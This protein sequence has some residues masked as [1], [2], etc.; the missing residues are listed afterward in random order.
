MIELIQFPWS[1]FC[2][3]ARAILQASEAKFK[4][5]NIPN[6]D[7]TLVWKLTRGQS[8]HVPL[9]RDGAKVVFESGDDTQDVARYLDQKFALG[10]FPAHFD[11]LQD[12]VWR[13]IE[14]VVETPEFKLSDSHWREYVPKADALGFVRHKERKFGRG[15]LDRWTTQRDELLA[16]FTAAL[17]PYEAMLAERPF[18]LDE[19][20]RFVDFDLYGMC[21]NFLWTGHYELPTGHRRL[22]DWHTRMA[23]VKLASFT[24]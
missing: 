11:G 14:E 4:I 17:A 9:V 3:V 18:L 1:N 2:A 8:Y 23:K 12:I 15:C 22:R 13:H 21:F 16:E 5:S 20:P 10:L 7:R 24:K 19:R 6:G